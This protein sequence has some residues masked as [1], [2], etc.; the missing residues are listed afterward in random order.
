MQCDNQI[1]VVLLVNPM[2]AVCFLLNVTSTV[3]WHG[4][5]AVP[6]KYVENVAVNTEKADVK[7]HRKP[8]VYEI[9]M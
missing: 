5:A 6:K 7:L 8:I 3:T 9:Q 4:T 1:L 2:Q